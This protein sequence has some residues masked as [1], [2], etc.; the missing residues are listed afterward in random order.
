MVVLTTIVGGI[1]RIPHGNPDLHK[2]IHM[3]CRDSGSPFY[4]KCWILKES[5][6][7]DS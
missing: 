3:M 1:T 6:V 7:M 2:V 4:A 5:Y